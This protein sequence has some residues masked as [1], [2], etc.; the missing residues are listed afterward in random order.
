M[1]TF[2]LSYTHWLDTTKII[3][4]K[5]DEDGNINRLIAS[6]WRDDGGGSGFSNKPDKLR[7]GYYYGDLHDMDVKMKPIKTDR[8]MELYNNV[9][10]LYVYGTYP[11][12]ID[13]LGGHVISGDNNIIND[14]QMDSALKT[15]LDRYITNGILLCY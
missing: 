12:G 9:M 2:T 14:V 3:I 15:L 1:A 11:D 13:Y 10:D 8:Q 4:D 7:L 5:L 6:R